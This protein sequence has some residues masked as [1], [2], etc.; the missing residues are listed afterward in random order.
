[1]C[2][3]VRAA[4]LYFGPPNSLNP[5]NNNR[6]A[7]NLEIRG[8]YMFTTALQQRDVQQIMS[9]GRDWRGG[10]AAR[11]W[12]PQAALECT[13][14]RLAAT[15]RR[16]RRRRLVRA[17]ARLLVAVVLIDC[18][19]GC[20]AGATCVAGSV[21]PVGSGCGFARLANSSAARSVI[22][23]DRIGWR[24]AVVCSASA[25]F[26][27]PGNSSGAAAGA[28]MR[29]WMYSRVC[30][31]SEVACRVCAVVCPAGSYCPGSGVACMCAP[32]R[33][34]VCCRV[35]RQHLRS[36]SLSNM[37]CVYLHDEWRVVAGVMLV[38]LVTC[39]VFQLVGA[40]ATPTIGNILI[41]AGGLP[42]VGVYSYAVR[43]LSVWRACVVSA[44][45]DQRR[46]KCWK[47]NNLCQIGR[48]DGEHE[49]VCRDSRPNVR[50]YVASKASVES[51]GLFVQGCVLFW[52]CGEHGIQHQHPEPAAGNMDACGVL[53]RRLS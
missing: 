51:V 48:L 2:V 45:L 24:G 29:V 28:C 1:V 8:L 37:R 17:R 40:P 16:T 22:C 41:P 49:S 14:A 4:P 18:C 32:V 30:W 9:G 15:V 5:W 21:E 50:C 11:M 25:G 19:A 27:C 35:R 26:Y 13:S 42:S 53:A 31:L 44:V 36:E 52:V 3:C 10:A 38:D 47:Q 34:D 12:R 7:T 33:D 20:T 43:R 6:V 46:V 23:I 39:A